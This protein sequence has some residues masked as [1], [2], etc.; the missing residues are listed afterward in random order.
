[1]P[2]AILGSLLEK[3]YHSPLMDLKV[4]QTKLNIYIFLFL[5]MHNS[6]AHI[7]KKKKRT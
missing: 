1:M 5:G 6:H 2:W 4:G 3:V 7:G